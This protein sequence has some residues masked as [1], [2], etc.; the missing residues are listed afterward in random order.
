M[1]IRQLEALVGIADHRTFSNAA[2]ALGTVQSN[3][4]NR[5]ARL[6][7]ELGTT[8]VDRAS[9]NLTESGAIVVER[10][11]RVLAE[12]NAIASDVSE[13][14]ADIRGYVS[15]GMIGTAGRWIVPLLLQAQRVRFPHISLRITEGTNSVIEPQVVNGQIDLAVLAWPVLAPELAEVDLF[16][17]DLVLIIDR[18]HELA[19]T[20]RSVTFETLSHY[21]LLLPFPGTPIRREIDEAAHA[22]GIELRPIIELDGL[23]TIASMTFDGHGPSIL[24]ATMLSPHLRENFT[25]IPIEGIAQRRV[26]LV[27]RRF[28]FPAAPVRAIHALLIDVVKS[29][30][31][32]P[33]GVFV[34]S[35]TPLQ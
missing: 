4:S 35:N 2:D 17:E 29:A 31:R 33:E 12:V 28:G 11:R 6:E 1:E 15:L 9:G 10:A 30:V 20:H 5:I 8:L 34:P 21:E 32:T 24:P 26:S 25:A 18:T 19:R 16:K 22:H 23:R 7:A 13:L 27:N 14:N 3:I